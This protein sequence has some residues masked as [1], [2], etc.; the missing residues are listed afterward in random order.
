MMWTCVSVEPKEGAEL[1]SVH[2][3]IALWNAYAEEHRIEVEGERARIYG[4]EADI[5]IDQAGAAY[6]QYSDRWQ[7]GG[8]RNLAEH[9]T[10][11]LPGVVLTLK[12][13]WTGEEPSIIRERWEGGA[14]TAVRDSDGPMQP[15][16]AAGRTPADA[17]AA[18]LTAVESL[19]DALAMVRPGEDFWEGFN[20]IEGDRLAAVFDAAGF[21]ERAEMIRECCR[22][23]DPEAWAEVEQ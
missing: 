8:L 23:A 9:L 5:D 10:R 7:T 6:V 13:E 4:V 15:L 21:P 22:E 2:R 14:I 11:T 16:D 12:E 1:P 20:F 3:L 17:L 18:V 19:G